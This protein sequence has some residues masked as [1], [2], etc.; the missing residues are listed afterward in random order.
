MIYTYL[1]EHKSS[2]QAH[3]YSAEINGGK[4]SVIHSIAIQIEN[5]LANLEGFF[6]EFSAQISA[7]ESSFESYNEAVFMLKNLSGIFSEASL[8]ITKY[9]LLKTEQSDERR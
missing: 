8:Y 1:V 6:N 9:E 5:I 2:G 3:N 7:L 4:M